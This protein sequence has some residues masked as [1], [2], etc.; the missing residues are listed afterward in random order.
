MKKKQRNAFQGTLYCSFLS[1]DSKQHQFNLNLQVGLV[2]FSNSPTSVPHDYRFSWGE[3]HD[4]SCT[5]AYRALTVSAV[6]VALCSATHEYNAQGK[7]IARASS[8]SLDEPPACLPWR[9][10]FA[11]PWVFDVGDPLVDFSLSLSLSLSL[12]SLIHI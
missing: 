8:L 5:D 2:K 1:L 9:Y 3:K 4:R 12:L 6:R 7:R 11:M 10:D